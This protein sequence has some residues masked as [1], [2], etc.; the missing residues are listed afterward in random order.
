MLNTAYNAKQYLAFSVEEFF[1]II[2]TAFFAALI[3][4]MRDLLFEHFGD[5]YG[6]QQLL[7]MFLFCIFALLLVVWLCKVVAIRLGH[8]IEYKAHYI[9]LMLGVVLSFASAGYL[10]LFLPG[11]FSYGQPT[12]LHIGKW[13]SY[14]KGWE[15]GLIAGSFSLFMIALVLILSPLYIF[16]RVELY[17]HAMTAA[18]LF[19]LYSCIPAPGFAMQHSGKTN[20]W[21]RYLHGTTFG[22]ELIYISRYWWMALCFTVLVFWALAYLL[23]VLDER[24]GLMVYVLSMI[25][26]AFILWIYH[27]FFKQA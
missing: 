24:V 16:T 27:L 4:S 10:P 8:T 5:V 25:L 19:A 23:T 12:R 1:Q 9:G 6:I 3:L 26:G 7:F 20:D 22:L 14:H 11:G 21:F 17:L 15:I 13:R 18:I 2:I